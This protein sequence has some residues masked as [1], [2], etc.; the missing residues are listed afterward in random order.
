MRAHGGGAG[1]ALGEGAAQAGLGGPSRPP[2]ASAA[3]SDSEASGSTPRN[4]SSSAGPATVPRCPGRGTG[5]AARSPG[6]PRRA[7]AGRRATK[8]SSA[9]DGQADLVLGQALADQAGDVAGLVLVAGDGDGG[10]GAS[11]RPCA[12]RSRGRSSPA[13]IRKKA[14]GLKA[15][16]AWRFSASAAALSGPGLVAV[17]PQ[18]HQPAAAH[19]R[20]GRQLALQP[21]GVAV[22]VGVGQPGGRRRGRRDRSVDLG[23]QRVGALAHL[24]AVA[25]VD[26]RGADLLGRGAQEA[27][28]VGP[29]GEDHRRHRPDGV[30]PRLG[31]R[32]SA[33]AR[34]AAACAASRAAR[35]WPSCWATMPA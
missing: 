3:A 17:D 4:A 22:D 16:S 1:L 24:A 10:L 20:Q 25:A 28:D 21:A 7:R 9:S 27:L 30:P 11:R 32:R 34:A 14:S 13:S 12:G 23:G 5:P 35:F 33:T 19:Q 2:K 31:W 6:G 15:P 18:A 26:Q 29:L 8:R